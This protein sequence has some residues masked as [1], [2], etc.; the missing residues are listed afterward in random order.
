MFRA[1]LEPDAPRAR[2]RRSATI[3]ARA[4]RVGPRRRRSVVPRDRAVGKKKRP[5][6]LE[7]KSADLRRSRSEA[8]SASCRGRNF[9]SR[10]YS[11]AMA[12]RGP[13]GCLTL[14]AVDWIDAVHL[15]LPDLL[16]HLVDDLLVGISGRSVVRHS[17]A[18]LVFERGSD[19]C[20]WE[21]TFTPR[22]HA[23]AATT[24]SQK[25]VERSLLCLLRAPAYRHVRPP[26]APAAGRPLSNQM[27][28]SDPRR[29]F[30]TAVERCPSPSP[31]RCDCIRSRVAR[32]RPVD[33]QGPA[34]LIWSMGQESLQKRLFHGC[35]SRVVAQDEHAARRH[36]LGPRSCPGKIVGQGRL[37]ERLGRGRRGRRGPGS[38]SSADEGRVPFRG[39]AFPST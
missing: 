26:S 25:M 35:L 13:R 30:E 38:I 2:S 33:E 28:G 5:P 7:R 37:V 20:R 19:P 3:W 27:E 12:A 8:S 6:V 39:A 36:D 23:R 18:D 17:S 34:P 16:H 14:M 1:N 4:G 10:S 15:S 21:M 11:T 24:A 31:F 22:I 9:A 32:V 29:V